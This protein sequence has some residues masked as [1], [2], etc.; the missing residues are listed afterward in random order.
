MKHR[1]SPLSPLKLS[2][3]VNLLFSIGMVWNWT[4][5]HEPLPSAAST[6]LPR[7]KTAQTKTDTTAPTKQQ[8]FHW[9][10]LDAP[11]FPSFVRNLRSIGCPE[12]T[13]HD[14]IQGELKEIYTPRRQEV[15]RELAAAPPQFRAVLEQRLQQLKAEE[16]TMLATTLSSVVGTTSAVADSRSSPPQAS[17][18]TGIGFTAAT[19]GG[20]KSSISSL[21]PA[22]FLVGNDPSKPTPANELPAK[23]TDPRLNA[24]T[25]AVISQMRQNF[26]N[27]IQDTGADP[28]SPEYRRRWIA[29]QR[30]SDDRFSSMFGGDYFIQSQ[31]QAAHAA[32]AAQQAKP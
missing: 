19:N 17:D 25:A 29:A 15:E 2:M 16:C 27:A 32:A 24:P 12:A 5:R 30:A 9:K 20:V 13:I 23:P 26:I 14:I 11:D 8:P 10:L 21:T 3:A 28:S 22:A 6:I 4:Y 31:I 1:Q 7:A 18:T